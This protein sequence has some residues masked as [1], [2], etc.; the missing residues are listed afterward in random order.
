VDP[1]SRVWRDDAANSARIGHH[2]RIAALGILNSDMDILRQSPETTKTASEE[3]P[4]PGSFGEKSLPE[5]L[6]LFQAL[7]FL[8]N[9]VE[10]L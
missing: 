8:L 4:T 3:F 9:V 10:A 1:L 6:L 7:L 5:P 2:R